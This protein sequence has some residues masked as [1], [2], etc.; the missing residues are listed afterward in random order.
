MACRVMSPIMDCVPDYWCNVS[1]HYLSRYVYC[2]SGVRGGRSGASGASVF[3][4]CQIQIHQDR[5]FR[6]RDLG[7]R[8]CF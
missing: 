1:D 4:T 8:M 7:V 3:S 2:Y 6:T 5:A